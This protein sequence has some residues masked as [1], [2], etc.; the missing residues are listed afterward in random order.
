MESC[1]EIQSFQY[2]AKAKKWSIDSFPDLDSEYTLVLVF[3]A[4]EF[5]N[6]PE[7]IEALAKHY[8]ESKLIGCSTAGEISDEYVYDHSISVSVMKFDKTAIEV[9][10]QYISDSNSS[11][12]IG[13]QL[14]ESFD[15]EYLS[16]L[17]V[18][19]DGLNVNGTE[20]VNGMNSV[21]SE[22]LTITGGLAGDG[23]DFKQT[24]VICNGKIKTNCV[25]AV[26]FYG[27]NVRISH[28]SKGGW[29][30]F[31]PERRITKA[32]NNVLYELD[33]K[34]ALALYKE[35]LGEKASGLP[36]TGLLFPLA[37]RKNSADEKVLVRTILSVDESEQSLTF[38]GDMPT[39]YFAQLM[40]ANFDRLISGANE[41]GQVALEQFGDKINDMPAGLLI[42]ISC[43][44]RRLVLGERID[45]ETEQTLEIFP[46][47]THQIGYYS[48]GELSPYAQ[49][50]CD[51]HN[52][53]MTLTYITESD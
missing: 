6:D 11:F 19:S 13:K 49:G 2:K 3:A 9:K 27:E 8:P 30:I 4:P 12:L 45:E 25:V 32:S 51:L 5:I 29:D 52:Q 15:D 1:V 39:G 36:S 50:D 35:Y 20:F 41:A 53:T 37:I 42:A 38:A 10:S 47:G 26:G 43:V 40:R 31:G 48:Y 7:P 21:A 16:A 14:L 22:G 34:P 23:S 17:F 28:A 24:W 33:N 46:K 18:L 44:G